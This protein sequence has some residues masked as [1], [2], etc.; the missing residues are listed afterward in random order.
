MTIRTAKRVFAFRK[1]VAM[2]CDSPQPCDKQ[3]QPDWEAEIEK[4]IVVRPDPN[5][6]VRFLLIHDSHV[7]GSG[8]RYYLTGLRCSNGKI[9]EIF[10]RDAK[11]G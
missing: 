7:K 6:V 10:H 1:G 11:A 9:Q 3:S 4:D 8:W 5:V 2:N